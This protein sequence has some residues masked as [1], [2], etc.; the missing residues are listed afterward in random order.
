MFCGE[1][2]W[3]TSDEEDSY[4]SDEPHY[5]NVGALLLRG[6]RVPRLLLTWRGITLRF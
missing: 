2:P 1:D 3:D 5:Q 4:D 6:L